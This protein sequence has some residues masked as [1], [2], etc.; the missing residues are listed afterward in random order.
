MWWVQKCSGGVEHVLSTVLQCSGVSGMLYLPYTGTLLL[1]HTEHLCSFT[2]KLMSFLLNQN[3]S[4]AS[5]RADRAQGP[6]VSYEQK[7]ISNRCAEISP[8]PEQIGLPLTAA[9]CS[10]S[11]FP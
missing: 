7:G 9:P 6:A 2:M 3:L 1:L 4:F 8:L 5:R 11:Q 10:P